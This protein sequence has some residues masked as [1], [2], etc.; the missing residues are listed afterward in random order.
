MVS[1]LC[2]AWRLTLGSY[3]EIPGT[4]KRCV[5]PQQS[6]GVSIFT[7]RGNYLGEISGLRSGIE[8]IT[9]TVPG[10]LA[11]LGTGPFYVVFIHRK[12]PVV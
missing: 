9:D 10:G 12:L 5:P 11:E 3:Y 1:P 4:V 6:W 2:G 7:R 8:L